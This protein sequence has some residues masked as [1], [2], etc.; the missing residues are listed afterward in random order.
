MNTYKVIA[1]FIQQEIIPVCE[2]PDTIAGLGAI[3][4]GLILKGKDDQIDVELVEAMVRGGFEFQNVLTLRIADFLPE[5]F[6]TKLPILNLERVRKVI[7][8]P[9]DIDKEAA[10]RLLE[11]MKK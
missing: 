2:N 7:E 3:A 1:E 10:E 11:K 9:F 6:K 4:A 8:T 5:N